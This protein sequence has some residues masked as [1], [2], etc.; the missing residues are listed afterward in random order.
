VAQQN[1]TGA[2]ADSPDRGNGGK[3][4]GA[5]P[6]SEQVLE[7]E[8]REG[9]SEALAKQAQNPIASLIS[10][11][12]QWNSIPGTQWAPRAIEPTAQANRTLNV[13]NVQPVV[14]FPLNDHLTLISRTMCP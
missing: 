7:E 4:N 14:P 5:N 11:P 10:F 6:D 3:A 13:W 2:G 8:A 12:I 1:L 9:N